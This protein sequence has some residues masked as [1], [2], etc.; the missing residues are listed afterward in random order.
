MMANYIKASFKEVFH[1]FQY[2]K[3][4]IWTQR[5]EMKFI[6][7]YDNSSCSNIDTTFFN[8]IEITTNNLE[9][10]HDAPIPLIINECMGSYYWSSNAYSNNPQDKKD[11]SSL[12]IELSTIIYE[13]KKEFQDYSIKYLIN[14]IYMKFHIFKASQRENR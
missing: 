6:Y 4:N 7:K 12:S 11:I 1:C 14:P 2:H 5:Y 3:K 9:I 10:I 13:E 8:S